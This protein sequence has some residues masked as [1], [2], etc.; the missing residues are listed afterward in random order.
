MQWQQSID[1][2]DMRIHHRICDDQKHVLATLVQLKEK[3][4]DTYKINLAIENKVFMVKNMYS[5]K[6]R[7]LERHTVATKRVVTRCENSSQ[8]L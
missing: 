4:I 3:I 5:I 6:V 1:S 2:L 8:N 7:L